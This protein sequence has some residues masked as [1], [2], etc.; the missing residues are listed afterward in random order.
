LKIQTGS[1]QK[2]SFR[3]LKFRFDI[4]NS[5]KVRI[6]YKTSQTKSKEILQKF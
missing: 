4:S 5:L 6:A 2:I 1:A 3:F